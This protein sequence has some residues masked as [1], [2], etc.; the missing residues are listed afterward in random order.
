MHHRTLP[1]KTGWPTLKVVIFSPVMRLVL[2]YPNRDHPHWSIHELI[3]EDRRISAKSTA[4][5]LGISRER[6]G[7]IIH[8][9]LDMEK[10]SAKW[11][12][13][14]L[15]ADQK[16]QRCQSSEQLLEFFRLDPNDFLSRRDLWPWTKSGYSTMTRRQSNNQW[17]A[18]IAAHSAPKNSECNNPLEKFSPRFYPLPPVTF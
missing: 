11:V 13:K 1:S 9:H 5:Q 4:E 7:P 3:L 12:P 10:F 14:C 6:V 16:R 17:S 2:D 18:G 8:E 15:N